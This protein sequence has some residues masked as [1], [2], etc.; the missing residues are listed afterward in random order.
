M[1]QDQRR[2]WAPGHFVLFL[3]T[4]LALCSC[5]KQAPPPESPPP[6]VTIAKP[7]QKEI[8]EWDYFTGRNE[9]VENVNVTPRVS[10]YIDNIT[11]RAGDPVNKGD[12]LFVIDPRPYQAVLDQA[13]AQQRD[14]EAD[15]QLQEANF[16]RQERL[17]Q[18]GVIAKEDF[19]TALSNKNRAAARVLEA[20]ASVE[21]A[22]LNLTFTQ[23]TSPIA[24]RISREQVT[25]G[26]LVQ[27]D[28]TLLTNIVSVHPIYAYFNVD[29]RAVLHYQKQVREGKLP[30]VR[31]GSVPVY[32]QLENENGF[33]HQGTIDFVNN[34]FNASTGTL[35]V[36]GL[37]PNAN[38]V[39]TP[40]AFVRVRVAGTPLH[41]AIL[42][43][44]RAVGTDQGQ[45]FVLVVG[46]DNVVAVKTVELGPEA[47]GLRVVR[48]GLTGDEQVIINGIV[49]ARPGSKVNPQEGDMNQFKTNQL[50]L[51]TSSRTVPVD[52]A[53]AKG[54]GKPPPP[55]AQGAPSNQSKAGGSR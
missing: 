25:V 45:K 4:S 12:L 13:Q 41:Q 36:R 30:D 2:A 42:V 8:I 49:N 44:D 48:S 22:Q 11:F 26:N 3:A 39:L 5:N 6:P 21:S 29:E 27:A 52:D 7:I 14:A 10:G 34:Q 32:L 38:A 16:A 33:P 28:T 43:S 51:E 50:Q 35:Q 40:G 1:T 19:D 18:T 37:F 23:I 20:R 47:E 54:G 31:S 15:Q 17:R 9:A 24:G 46:N 55:P 53:K